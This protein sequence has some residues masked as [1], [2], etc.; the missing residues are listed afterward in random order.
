M[1]FL[2][3]QRR[4][5]AELQLQVKNG[6]ITERGLARRTGIS[7]PH[8]HNVLKGKRLFSWEA[9]DAVLLELKMTTADLRKLETTGAGVQESA[10]GYSE[11][12]E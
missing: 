10:A 9:A 8:I 12:S 4:L 11:R 1:T 5:V 6:Q 2:S 7:Q 3:M